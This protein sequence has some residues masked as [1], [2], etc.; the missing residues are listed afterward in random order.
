MSEKTIGMVLVAAMEQAGEDLIKARDITKIPFKL[1]IFGWISQIVQLRKL[2]NLVEQLLTQ[3]ELKSEPIVT[4]WIDAKNVPYLAIIEG[5]RVRL[6]GGDGAEYDPTLPVRN[7]ENPISD[8][9]LVSAPMATP[10]MVWRS[11]VEEVIV[12]AGATSLQVQVIAGSVM[13]FGTE[14]Q[15][16]AEPSFSNAAGLDRV[17]LIGTDSDAVYWVSYLMPVDK[18]A[19]LPVLEEESEPTV[20]PEPQVEP[21]PPLELIDPLEIVPELAV[22]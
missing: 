5:D 15:V 8:G 12:E 19:I 1:N 17:E 16:G 6:I 13:A 11:G 2:V 14:L 21:V 4:R 18:A 9:I 3:S 22:A 7:L 10:K 20:E